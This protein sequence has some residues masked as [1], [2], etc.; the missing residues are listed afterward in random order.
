M[1]QINDVEFDIAEVV[2]YDSTYQYDESISN[3]LFTI[4]VQSIKPYDKIPFRALPSNNNIKNIPLIGEYVLIYKTI[5]SQANAYQQ[6]NQCWYYITTVDI[7]S[8][9]HANLLPGVSKK[10]GIDTTS[11]DNYKPGK[12]FNLTTISPLQPYEGDILIEGRFGNSIRFSNTVKTGGNYYKQPKWSGTL[13]NSTGDPIIVLSNRVENLEGKKF[14]TEDIQRDASTLYLTS[15]QTLP[16]FRLNNII[17]TSTSETAFNG[18]QFIGV[19]DRVILKSKSDIIVLDSNS[20]VEINTPLLSIGEKPNFLKEY[21]LHSVQVKKL[22]D[23]IIDMLNY[24]LI[25]GSTPVTVNPALKALFD[26]QIQTAK[27]KIDNTLIK[28]DKA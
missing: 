5:N 6:R 21:G 9:V 19:A 8:S 12:T 14:V 22:F 17:R 10:I 11:D 18:S 16:N 1:D 7:Q 2:E 15:T 27:E 28:Q 25:A 24:G 3:S 26:T 4:N 13:S 20:A 23:T